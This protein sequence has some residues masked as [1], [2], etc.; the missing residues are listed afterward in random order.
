MASKKKDFKMKIDPSQLAVRAFD[1]D[2]DLNFVLSTWLK[3]Y[4]NSD[5]A[6]SIP[7]DIYF[8]FHQGLISQILLHPQ[9]SLTILCSPE[10]PDQILG[11]IAYNTEQPIIYY[12]YIKYPFRRLG[13]G[14][15]LFEGIK[16]HFNKQMEGQGKYVIYCTHKSRKWRDIARPLNLVYN[17]Y[18]TRELVPPEELSNPEPKKEDTEDD[19]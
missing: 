14:R 17:P 6:I 12:A 15:Y 3:S 9:N 11:Y 18:I 2:K 5:F 8:Q 4:R 10:D 19:S 16:K 7:N 13:L 1:V